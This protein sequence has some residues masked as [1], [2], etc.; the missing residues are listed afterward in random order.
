MRNREFPTFA[1]YTGDLPTVEA[2]SRGGR[3]EFGHYSFGKGGGARVTWRLNLVA[4]ATAN[5]LEMRAFLHSLRG[6]GGTFVMRMPAPRIAGGVSSGLQGYSDGTLHSDGTPFSD[7]VDSSVMQVSAGTSSG[8]VASGASSVTVSGFTPVAG[9][10][11]TLATANG[12]QLV[13]VSSVSGSTAEFRPALRAAVASGAQIHHGP[14]T[15]AFRVIGNVPAV[16]LILTRSRE[17]ALDCEE[18]Y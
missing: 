11:M 6:S 7:T 2:H 1:K 18:A 8:V 3:G 12:P 14:V 10:W 9:A 17:F 5:A 16:P 15:A 13:R 4:M